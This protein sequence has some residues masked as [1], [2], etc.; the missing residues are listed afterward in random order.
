MNALTF[1][2]IK[3][4]TV[5]SFQEWCQLIGVGGDLDQVLSIP[6]WAKL[7]GFSEKT[8]RE[9][10]D[11]GDGPDTVQLSPNRIGVRVCDHRTWLAARVRRKAAV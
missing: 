5:L 6:E 3:P 4:D 1:E 10:I 9:V 7:A 8:G 2:S 11:R